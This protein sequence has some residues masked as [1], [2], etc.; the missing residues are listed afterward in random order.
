MPTVLIVF[1]RMLDIPGNRCVD[2]FVRTLLGGKGGGLIVVVT[3]HAH[4]TAITDELV[5]SLHAENLFKFPIGDKG[6]VQHEAAVIKLLRFCKYKAQ[7]VRSGQNDFHSGACV[8]VGEQGCAFNEVLHQRDLI[9]E[10][11]GVAVP[12]VGIP[13]VTTKSLG[14]AYPNTTNTNNKA[15]SI[16]GFPL[17]AAVMEYSVCLVIY[18]PKTAFVAKNHLN[19]TSV[20]IV[21]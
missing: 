4:C 8:D 5:N 6:R 9:Y 20:E 1:Q 18:R 15:V 7:G 16:G 2:I 3:A 11:I 19:Y 10:H 13:S 17:L 14:T 12:N 21:P